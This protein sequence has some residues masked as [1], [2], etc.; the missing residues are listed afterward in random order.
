MASSGWS[1]DSERY[2]CQ[3]PKRTSKRTPASADEIR[4]VS[5]LPAP[6]REL[7]LVVQD[8]RRH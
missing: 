7:L 6:A 4:E 3:T 8:L 1:S 5:G 2:A